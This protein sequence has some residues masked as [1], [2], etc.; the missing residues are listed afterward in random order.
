MGF[1]IIQLSILGIINYVTSNLENYQLEEQP[2]SNEKVGIWIFIGSITYLIFEFSIIFIGLTASFF[3]YYKNKFDFSKLMRIFSA[4]FN[5]KFPV[6]I[7][8]RNSIFVGIVVSILTVLIVYILLKNKNKFSNLVV[9]SSIGISAAF[10]AMTLLYLNILFRINFPILVIIGHLLIAV[11]IGYSFMYQ[12]ITGFDKSLIEAANI[13]GASVC[14]TFIHIEFPLLKSIFLSTFL[15]IFAI[16]YG[17]F[18][19]VYTMQM[20]DFFPLAS[21]IN[22]QIS[23]QKLLPESAAFSATNVLIIFALFWLA[24]KSKK[25]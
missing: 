24:K 8:M 15:Q 11:P 7:S 21:V 16:I 9:I 12:H 19:I 20:Q 6:I 1:A 18:T 4:E 22:Y 25:K 13:G 23:S 14:K 2:K 5:Q 10:L 3:D 17:E